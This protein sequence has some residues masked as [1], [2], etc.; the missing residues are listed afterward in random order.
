MIIKITF[1]NGKVMLFGDSYKPWTMQ[2]DEYV[3]Y[4]NIK[5][6]KFESCKDKWIGWG[7]LKWCSEDLFQQ[8]L[9]REGCQDNES[10]NPN[11]R[12]YSDMIF[13]ENN[14]VKNVVLKILK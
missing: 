2:F 12:K 1:D 14:I 10:D 8:Q 9:N 3:G 7:G 6:T 5:P 4:S 13:V 11:P